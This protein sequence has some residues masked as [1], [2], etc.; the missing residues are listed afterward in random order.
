[1]IYREY[2]DYILCGK[3]DKVYLREDVIAE[4]LDFKKKRILQ[5]I[6]KNICWHGEELE[7]NIYGNK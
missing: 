4:V 6:I 1:M 3:L 5:M 7:I 2:E